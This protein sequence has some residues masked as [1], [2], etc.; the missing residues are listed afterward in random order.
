MKLKLT[1]DNCEIQVNQSKT[2]GIPVVFIHGNSL[3]AKTFEKQLNNDLL[4]DYRLIAFDIQGH[5]ES[6]KANK[7]EKQY[8]VPAYIETLLG[9]INKLKIK[10]PIIVGHSLGGH[11]AINALS[12]IPDTKGLV[13][14]GTPPFKLPPEM[15][16]A[17]F[18]VPE[19][20]LA[21]KPN[22][23]D[24]EAF[25][26]AKVFC[27]NNETAEFLKTEI[28]KT[29]PMARAYLGQSMATGELF[30]ETKILEKYDKPVAIFHGENDTAVNPNYFNDLNI[31]TLWESKVQIIEKSGHSVQYE[32][33]S[34][35]NDKLLHFL[36]YVFE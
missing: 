23:S 32:N 13:I 36:D 1:I 9:V 17:Y 35:F 21:F 29:D 34:D 12:K 19:I 2:E 30:D 10:N 16:K 4:K 8:C 3:S 31:P 5:G 33:E 20:G 24:D 22:L 14:F 6:K 18:P 7:P 27:N 15:D 26:L 25:A 28:L 11:I